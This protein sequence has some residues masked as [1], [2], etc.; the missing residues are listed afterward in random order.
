MTFASCFEL[1]QFRNPKIDNPTLIKSIHCFVTSLTVHFLGSMP[2]EIVKAIA[3]EGIKFLVR[4]FG[5]PGMEGIDRMRLWGRWRPEQ[6]W[7]GAW[8]EW[9][10]IDGAGILLWAPRVAC[11]Q[12]SRLPVR[13]CTIHRLARFQPHTRESD[14]G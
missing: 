1:C 11:P 6:V 9:H 7:A 3:L 10:V 8:A 2:D 14:C 5:Q 13:H 12:A 4:L